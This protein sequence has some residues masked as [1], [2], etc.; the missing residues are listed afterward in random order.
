M[1]RQ[2]SQGRDLPQAMLLRWNRLTQGTPWE[3]ELATESAGSAP[4][5][6]MVR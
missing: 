3:I 6:G 1:I 5:V 4:G 2:L